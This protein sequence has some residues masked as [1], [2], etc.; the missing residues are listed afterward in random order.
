[1]RRTL[2]AFVITAAATPA[3]AQSPAEIREAVVKALV[4]VQKAQEP[5][6]TANKQV[7]ASCH[8]QYQPSLAYRAARERGV[9]VN[10]TIARADAVKAFTFADVDKAIQ[11]QYVI[12]PSVDDAYRMMGAHAAGVAPNLGAAIYARLL[13]SRQNADGT[14]DGFHQ[15]PPSSYSRF[16]MATLGL[17]AVQL[18][19]HPSQKAAADAAVARARGYLEKNAAPDTEGRAYQLLGLK[20]AG[21]DNGRLRRL[22]R[23]LLA[24]QQADGGWESRTGRGSDVYSTGQALV[25]LHDA[26]GVPAS[27]AAWRKGIAWL[28]K[29]Q[30]ADGTWHATTRLRPPAPLS[31]PYFN[32][33]YPYERDQFLSMS[34]ASWAIMALSYA[35]GPAR[36]VTIAPL[37]DTLPVNVEPWVETALFGSVADLRRLLDGGLSPN[38]ATAAGGTTVLMAAAPDVEKMRLLLDRGADVNAR[39]KSRFSALMVTAQYQEGDAAINLLLDSGAQMAPPEGPAPIFNANPFS[40][41]VY[42][43]N[44]R[45]LPRLKAAGGQIDGSFIAIGTSRTTP[46]LG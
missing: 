26:A 22:G 5:W 27:D 3:T 14:W 25:A 33:G 13:I 8:H 1:M 2:M 40:L 23:E 11:Y 18:Y 36:P 16:T 32:A 10:E 31:P 4:P 35:L 44:F 28:L 43:G 42:A 37:P 39:A 15:R 46:M 24:T 45:S 7:C 6:F 12:E 21:A 19:R 20:W 34:G 41:A 17:R 29:T 30:A 9:P 38:A